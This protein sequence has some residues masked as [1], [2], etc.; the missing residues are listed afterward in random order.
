MLIIGGDM[1]PHS[2][3]FAGHLLGFIS[4]ML[5]LWWL[6]GNLAGLQDYKLVIAL[7]AVTGLVMNH[8]RWWR[9]G[10]KIQDMDALDKVNYLVVSNY[11]VMILL[12]V[13]L[14]FKQ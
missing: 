5:G 4:I 2:M 8:F 9:L 13:L 10:R 12:F 6:A 1:R 3:L 7:A 11:L 14:D